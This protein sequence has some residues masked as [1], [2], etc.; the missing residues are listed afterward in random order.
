VE[1]HFAS[2]RR[3]LASSAFLDEIRD[4]G[5][6]SGRLQLMTASASLS[7]STGNGRVAPKAVV[8]PNLAANL[9]KQTSRIM[10]SADLDNLG[11]HP[12]HFCH[13]SST[14]L[15]RRREHPDP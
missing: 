4:D 5:A 1:Q 11:G 14:R 2:G 7:Y 3:D 13:H 15:L 6:P 8:P 12:H 10:M 9:P